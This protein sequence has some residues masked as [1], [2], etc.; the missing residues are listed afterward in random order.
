MRL[1]KMLGLAGILALVAMA[2]VGVG[3]ASADSACLV[4]PENGP[5]GECPAGSV[6]TGPIIGLASNALFI[7]GGVQ[8]ECKSEFLADYDENEGAEEGVLYLILSLTFTECKNGCKKVIAENLPYLLL[9][10]MIQPGADAHAI[11]TEDGKGRPAFL[12]E[13]CGGLNCL[14]ETAEKALLNYILEEKEAKPLV[15]AWAAGNL[16]ITRGGDSPLCPKE[17]LFEATYLTYEDV[18]K[19]E[20]SELFFTALP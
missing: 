11:L 19:V 16:P 13:N 7:G 4:D 9:I 1:I 14:Y 2:F 5:K 6:W 10:L 17:G 8:T 15:G 20:G 3:A 12:L 18:N